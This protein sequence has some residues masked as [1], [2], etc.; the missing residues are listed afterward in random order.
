MM[1]ADVNNFVSIS[2]LHNKVFDPNFLK[3]PTCTFFNCSGHI[4]AEPMGEYRAQLLIYSITESTTQRHLYIQDPHIC[5]Y[6]SY[7]G[8]VPTPETLQV[9]EIFYSTIFLYLRAFSL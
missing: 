4:H 7:F 9:D 3:F 1:G 5:L 2:L 8:A 6:L